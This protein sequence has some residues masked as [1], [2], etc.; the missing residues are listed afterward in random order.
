MSEIAA[1]KVNSYWNSPL[2]LAEY[3]KNHAECIGAERDDA[4]WREEFKRYLPP[5]PAAVADIGCG[6]GFASLLLA[7]LGYTVTGLDQA[8]TML[9]SAREKAAQ[10]KADIRFV[11]GDAMHPLLPAGSFDVVLSRWVYW[12]LPDPEAAARNALN[13]L[14]PGGMLAVFDGQWFK[15][16]SHTKDDAAR[17]VNS[18]PYDAQVSAQKATKGG[19]RKMT[20][21][22]RSSVPGCR[23]RGF[24]RGTD[25]TKRHTTS[26]NVTAPKTAGNSSAARQRAGTR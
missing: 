15:G 4:V 24:L 17:K 6:T 18:R 14:R 13:L 7:E 21:Q 11:Q 19:L 3:D 1:Q 22:V 12:T 16:K 23:A 2:C 5:A 26:A 9:A 25:S 8:E 20:P 10:R